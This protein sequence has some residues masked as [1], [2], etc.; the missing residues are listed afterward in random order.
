MSGA[1][2]LRT[3]SAVEAIRGAAVAAADE[4]VARAAATATASRSRS[5]EYYWGSNGVAANYAMMLLIA[6]RIE[7]KPQYVDCAQDTLH[8]L[9]GSNTFNTSFVTHVGTKCAMHPH[10]RPSAADE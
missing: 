6:N 3:R 4:I 8:Y 5:S 7:P 10:H 1:A 2:T 9:L